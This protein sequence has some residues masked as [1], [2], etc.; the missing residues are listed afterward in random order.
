MDVFTFQI[1]AVIPSRTS[2]DVFCSCHAAK[3]VLP[4][5]QDINDSE[6]HEH[7]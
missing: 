4:S 3:L 2:I 6:M 5:K 1:R 7:G